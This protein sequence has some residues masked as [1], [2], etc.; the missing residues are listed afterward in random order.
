MLKQN[1][2]KLFILLLFIPIFSA[3]GLAQEKPSN[4]QDDRVRT[5][6]IPIS[7]FTKKEQKGNQSGELVQVGDLEV[8]ENG[9]IKLFYQSAASATRRLPWRF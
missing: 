5:M 7:I 9:D 1:F 2:V 4:K 3:A 8:K 6:T